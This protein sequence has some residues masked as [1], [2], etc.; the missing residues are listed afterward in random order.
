MKSSAEIR[1]A[2]DA[3]ISQLGGAR[4]MVGEGYPV[5]LS[6]LTARVETICGAIETLPADQRGTFEMPVVGLI[7]ELN[8]LTE[9]LTKQ[10]DGIAK[11]LKS[12]A[13]GAQASKAYSQTTKAPGK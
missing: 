12:I 3:T 10:R 9:D 1:S 6:D 11:G 7:D 4:R 8:A 2:L 5:D 13:S